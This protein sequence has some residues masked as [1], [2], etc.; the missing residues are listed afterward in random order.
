V[1]VGTVTA[2]FGLILLAIVG[3]LTLLYLAILAK[4]ETEAL[5]GSRR[6]ARELEEARKLALSAEESRLS[7]LREDIQQGLGTI[8][9]KVSEILRRVD[10][11]GRVAVRRETALTPEPLA[12]RSDPPRA[13]PAVAVRGTA[14][15]ATGAT[16]DVAGTRVRPSRRPTA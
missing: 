3:G 5:V 1:L 14:G 11:Q 16:S 7:G 6:S 15:T 9:T 10:A 2:P 13:S 12:P 8:D 4:M